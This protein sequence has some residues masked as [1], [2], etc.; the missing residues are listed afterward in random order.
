MEIFFALL[1]KLLPLYFIIL[2]G[3]FAA[4]FL[5]IETRMVGN[6]MMYIIV[7][8]VIFDGVSKTQ[9]SLSILSLPLLLWVLCT[10]I[11]LLFLWLG[12]KI[13]SDARANVLGLMAGTGNLGYF[14]VPVAMILF[15]EAT[16]GIYITMF[17]GST[18]FENTIGFFITARGQHTAQ[19]A[20]QKLVRLP[21]VYAFT[22]G[23]IVS[24]AG[25]RAPEFTDDL[26]LNLRGAYTILGMMI[27]GLGIG[28]ITRLPLSPSFIG[29]AFASRF[30]VWPLAAFSIIGIDSAYFNFFTENIYHALMLA[31]IVPIAAN[32]VVIATVL[33]AYPKKVATTVLLSTFFALIYIPVMVAVFF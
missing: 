27:I 1:L 14:G 16:V 4:R 26:F 24:F 23:V 11:C 30:I 19:E 9:I 2:L 17:V 33:N 13:W 8:L 32:S 21:A 12:K 3:F 7:P 5:K 25:L 6:L 18:L 20:L 10:I 22:A 28:A 31:S 15:D 29:L